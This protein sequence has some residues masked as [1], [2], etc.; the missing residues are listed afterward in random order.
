M[1]IIVIG[2]HRSGTSALAGLLHN[3]NIVMG[4]ESTFIPKPSPE[5]IKGFYENYTFR[6]LND[7]IIEKC[8]YVIKSWDT[9]VP[10]MSANFTTKYRMKRILRRYDK[11]YD[12]WGWKDPRTCLTLSL[13]LM[14]MRTLGL[15]NKCKILYISRDPFAVAYSMTKR[16]NTT[17][18]SAL[19]L[20]LIYSKFSLDSIA[21]F[22]IDTHYMLYEELCN[23][24]IETSRSVFGFLGQ[25]FDESIV[26]H[27][28]DP[29]LNRSVVIDRRYNVPK[30]LA[31][32]VTEVKD[33]IVRRAI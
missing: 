20:W 27:F 3:N 6:K 5:N 21:S 22:N 31:R 30:E 7:H 15:L 12:R 29:K 10:Q 23:N 14:E 25:P 33:D 24:P 16:K 19:R 17:Y 18:E 1:I 4:E 11:R 2:M 28:I 32:E 26:N 9:Y 8:G 13:W